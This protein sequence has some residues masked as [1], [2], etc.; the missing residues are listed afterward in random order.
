MDMISAFTAITPPIVAAV[1]LGGRR[2]K[3]FAKSPGEMA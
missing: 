2:I 1:L 3:T